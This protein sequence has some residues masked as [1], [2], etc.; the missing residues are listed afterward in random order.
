MSGT[1]AAPRDIEVRTADGWLLGRHVDGVCRFDAIPYAAPPF[2]ARRFAPPQP[3]AT[4]SG[5]RDARKPGPIA[6]QGPSRLVRVMGDFQREQDEDCLSLT[7]WTPAIDAKRRPVLFWLHGGAFMTGAGALDWYDGARLAREGD[8]VVVSP[9]YRLGA[10]GFLHVPGL[11]DGNLGLLDQEASLAWVRRHIS[12]FGGDPAQV[13]AM[14]QSAGALSVALLLARMDQA[15]PTIHRAILQSAPLGMRPYTRETATIIG[16][17]FL[18]SAGIDLNA[19]QAKSAAQSATVE[20]LIAAQASVTS[21]VSQRFA[22]P[23]QPAPAFYPVGDGMVVPD[24]L[25][26]DA[27]MTRAA[28]RVDVM[29]GSTRDEMWAFMDSAQARGHAGLTA[30]T[31]DSLAGADRYRRH[32]GDEI[33][34][35]PSWQWALDAILFR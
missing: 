6:P 7:V 11:S 34:Q 2:G 24:D 31:A 4:W 29:I 14:G 21:L 23:G 33:F 19:A 27:A 8:M 30:G 35:T 3:V 20:S 15:R 18:E 13:T 32:V 1:S 17:E 28:G 5:L 9:N 26:F 25:N 10:L 22:K 12:D 16:R